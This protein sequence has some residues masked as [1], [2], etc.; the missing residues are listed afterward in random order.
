M[1]AMLDALLYAQPLPDHAAAALHYTQQAALARFT[2]GPDLAEIPAHALDTAEDVVLSDMDSFSEWL[3]ASCMYQTRVST[4]IM[5]RDAGELEAVIESARV[6]V[7]A[8]LLLYPRPEVR[9]R[10]ADE[11]RQ[12]YLTDSAHRI[13]RIA[14]EVL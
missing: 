5:P 4:P 12:R 10:A 11:L 9:A 8:A 1:S 2:A 6:P 3:S 14:S 13:H 7:L